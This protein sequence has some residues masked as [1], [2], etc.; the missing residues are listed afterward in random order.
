VSKEKAAVAGMWSALDLALRQGVQFIVSL[1]LARLLMP[2]DFGV[3]ALLTFFSMLSIVFVQ[4]GISLALVQR[5]QTSLEEESAVFWWNLGGSCLC[6]VA[7]VALGPWAAG[8]FGHPVLSPLMFVAAAQVVLSALG[9][10]QTALLT[11]QLRFAVLTKAGIFASLT[12]GTAGIGAALFGLGVWAL[13]I[14][15]GTMAMVNTLALWRLSSWRPA[16]HARFET[17]R[18]LFGFGSW[19]SFS[20][21]LEVLYTQGFALLIGKLHGVRDL[22]LYNRALALQLLPSTVLSSIIGRIA[23]PLFS[24]R[25]TDPEAMRR[26]TRMAISFAMLLNVPAMLGLMFLSEPVVAGLYGEKW[27]PAAQ[28]LSILAASGTLF[29]LHVINLNVLLAQGDTRTFFKIEIGKKVVGIACVAAGSLF[30]IVG[31]AWSQVAASVLALVLNAWPTR[32]TIGYGLLAQLADLAGI[33]FAGGV[34]SLFLLLVAPLVDVQPLAKLALMVPAG[35]LVYAAVGLL[36][37]LRSF[38]E[39]L[40]LAESLWRNKGT[41][42]RAVE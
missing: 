19:L 39:A 16:F 4:G 8:F 20:S 31:L 15:I 11:R 37:R 34:M 36:L 21:L 40:A 25:T 35:A 7:L 42:L 18:E 28:I 3:I 9:S 17:I 22:G 5:T 10:V 30:G 32:R 2:A 23:L 24:T 29:P 26:G 6:A 14:Q 38:T 27:L 13:A 33:A 1:I 12:S 41:S